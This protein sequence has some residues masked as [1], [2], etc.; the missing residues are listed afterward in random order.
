MHFAN[1]VLDHFLGDF[2][3]SDNAIA[4]R[5]DR[6]DRV[7]RLAH[8]HLGVIANGFDALD[9]VNSLNRDDAGLIEDDALILDVNQRVGR[10]QIDSHVLRTEFEKISEKAHDFCSVP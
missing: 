7:R 3:V 1:E 8:H 4:Q 9:A 6:F 10:P 2:D 5:T